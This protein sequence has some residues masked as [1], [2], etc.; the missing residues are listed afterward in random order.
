MTIYLDNRRES[1]HSSAYADWSAPPWHTDRS[2]SRTVMTAL[3]LGGG[4]GPK[5]VSEMLWKLD[6]DLTAPPTSFHAEPR[7]TPDSSDTEFAGPEKG[8]Q[9]VWAGGGTHLGPQWSVWSCR[10]Q[11]QG[12]P[13]QASQ[14]AAVKQHRQPNREVEG[15]KLKYFLKLLMLLRVSQ[16]HCLGKVLLKT[17]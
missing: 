3:S 11:P 16:T 12:Q 4:I 6:R 15:R 13:M 5:R 9:G 7:S 8:V 14:D 17:I 10:L 1:P 2:V